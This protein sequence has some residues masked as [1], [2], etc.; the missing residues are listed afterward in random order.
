MS[1]VSLKVLRQLR[2][3]ASSLL[4]NIVKDLT[5]FKKDDGTFRRK[6]DSRSPAWDINVT[7]TCSCLM[8]LALSD[9]FRAFYKEEGKAA[10]PPEQRAALIFRQLL[11]A[12]WMSSGL[13]DNNAFT[14]ALVLRAYGFLHEE[15]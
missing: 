9:Q 1:E 13:T 11:E 4:G 3:R 5:P 8:A 15:E 14:T 10:T 2:D 12:P 6:P 7:T